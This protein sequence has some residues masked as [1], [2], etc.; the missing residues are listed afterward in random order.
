MPF[1]ALDV[2]VEARRQDLVVDV[3]RQV[4]HDRLFQ[5]R[6]IPADGHHVVNAA[7]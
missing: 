6:L 1:F 3:R 4:M 2:V 7:R 5:C